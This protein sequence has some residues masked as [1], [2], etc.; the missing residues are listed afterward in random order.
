MIT[1]ESAGI[2]DVGLKR[3]GNEDAF[4]LENDLKLF[5]VADGMG[6]HQAGEVA[7]DLVV[8]TIKDYMKR[9]K[10]GE[11]VEELADAQ[12]NLSK[13]AN[14]LMAAINLANHV[15]YEA[16]RNKRAYRGMG[17]TVSAVYFSEDTL[18]AANVGD[19]PI[20]LIRNNEIELLSVSHTVLAEQM[21]MNLKKGRKFG[22]EYNHMLTRAMGVEEYVQA[23]I[24]E[25][26]CFKR[27]II[28]IASDGLTNKV[29]PEE[30]RD[31]AISTKLSRACHILVNMANKRGGDDN[32]TV[33]IIK[34]KVVQ[35]NKKGLW[36][37]MLKFM[38]F[39]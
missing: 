39:K 16:S 18:I 6:G 5:V 27:D 3:K 26:P 22:K 33:I 24:C 11:D 13:D 37:S 1:V 12:K 14:R 4:F 21:A 10:R 32:I 35:R 30:I 34:V 15:V 25:F 23:D 7:S 31:V 9:F 17:A 19:S 38:G 28:V 20:Y 2:T 36:G 8:R 29:T